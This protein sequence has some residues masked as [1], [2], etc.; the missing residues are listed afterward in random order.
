MGGWDGGWVGG[1]LS[2]ALPCCPMPER[3]GEW[4]GGMVS[5]TLPCCP[6]PERVGEWEGG[7]VGGMLS[8]MLPCCSMPGLLAMMDCC[9]RHHITCVP[10]AECHRPVCCCQSS[11]QPV[12][13]GCHKAD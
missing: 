13:R 7:W 5:P 6:M 4:V 8:P 1:M 3:V 10:V 2:P 11:S 9:L 12:S